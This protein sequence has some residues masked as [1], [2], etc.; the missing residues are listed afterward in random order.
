MLLHAPATLDNNARR[1]VRSGSA[2]R[3]DSP[4]GHGLVRQ[5]LAEEL[6][7]VLER[8]AIEAGASDRRPVTVFFKPGIF[9]HHQVGRAADIYAVGG[10]GLEEWKRRWDD[11]RR[12]GADAATP[13]ERRLI[14]EKEEKEN[15]G[16]RLYKAIQK[17]GQWSQ[18]YGYPIQFF[19][20]WTRSEGPGK[21]ISDFLLRAHRDHIHIAK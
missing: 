13:L 15:L 5:E 20:P 18:P 11:A 10:I 2:Y 17:Y 14:I 7:R 3:V 21:Q 4:P 6:E 1:P 16:W 9:G 8:F 12:R 19:G